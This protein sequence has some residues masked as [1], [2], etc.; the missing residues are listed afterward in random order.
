MWVIR[1]LCELLFSIF[2]N[3]S[4][5]P[6]VF[7]H[8]FT[9]NIWHSL[10]FIWSRIW[11]LVL[12]ISFLAGLMSLVVG[13]FEKL[14]LW[15]F[16]VIKQLAVPFT[17]TLSC[18]FFYLAYLIPSKFILLSVSLMDFLYLVVTAF[19]NRRRYSFSS[20]Y[21]FDVLSAKVNVFFFDEHAFFKSSCNFIWKLFL[22]L[23]N[24][25]F[26]TKSTRSSSNGINSLSCG[27]HSLL[28]KGIGSF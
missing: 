8:S 17:S 12:P 9:F 5:T 23:R 16:K 6:A 14:A 25:I 11:L 27:G 18:I 20:Q 3:Q 26:F 4:I 21:I 15:S 2:S 19:C 28:F 24:L 22:I 13:W 7:F 1:N 10:E